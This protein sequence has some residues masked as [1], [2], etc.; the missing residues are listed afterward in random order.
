MPLISSP[1]DNGNIVI[2]DSDD[3]NNIRL[4]IRGDVNRPDFFQWFNFTLK[5]KPGEHY[6][7]NIENAGQAKYPEW[8][9]Y[10]PYQTYASYGNDEWFTVPTRYDEETGKLTMELDL[11]QEEIQFAF[12]PPYTYARHLNLIEKAKLIPHCEVTSLGK[13]NEDE[14]DIFLLTFG[15]KAPHKKEIWLIA[16]QHPG[17]PQAEWYAEGLIEHL[18]D[19]PELLD[20]YTFRVVPNMNPDG[21]YHGNLRTNKEGNDLNRMW[22]DATVKDSP[23][24]YYVLQEMKKT[25]VDFFMDIH[26]DE[27]IPRPFLD[28]SHLSCS[29][30][31]EALEAQEKDFMELYIAFN[32]DMQ[33]ALNYGAKDRNE[34]ANMTM[35]GM[36][37]GDHFNCPSFT[38]EMP[39]KRWSI[40]E[41]KSLAR[42]FFMTLKAFYLELTKINERT[43]GTEPRLRSPGDNSF[44]RA[45]KEN[46]EISP[47]TDLSWTCS[48]L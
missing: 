16:R 6:V 11:A 36:Y 37:V 31:N 40:S 29:V 44:L 25:G 43:V 12:F 35:A 41:C 17:E 2:I 45:P 13:T 24:V 26:S 47:Q 39:T 30:A 20:N 8:N 33:N 1:I 18:A 48:N 7:L 21:T 4:N 5:G 27:I 46:V 38:L 9:Q 3:P 19:H 34:P 32:I 15:T 14:R 23:E 22:K 10:E 28:E 42:D